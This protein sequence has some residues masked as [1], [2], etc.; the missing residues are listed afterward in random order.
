MLF[1]CHL[2]VPAENGKKSW[3]IN[4]VRPDFLKLNFSPM[5]L[6]V[7]PFVATTESGVSQGLLRRLV[8]ECRD[9]GAIQKVVNHT[10][11]A[12]VS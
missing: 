11:E 10:C 6:H 2:S 5:L 4:T 1:T 9:T 7:A 12:W 8:A 3:T